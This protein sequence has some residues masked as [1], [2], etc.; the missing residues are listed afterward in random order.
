MEAGYQLHSNTGQLIS[1]GNNNRTAERNQASHEYNN[2]VVLS[3]QPLR[4]NHMF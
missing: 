4:E 2:A 3:L 1:L